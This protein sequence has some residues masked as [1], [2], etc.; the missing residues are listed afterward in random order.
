MFETLW[1]TPGADISC[2]E[3]SDEKYFHITLGGLLLDPKHPIYNWTSFGAQTEIFGTERPLVLGIFTF[4]WSKIRNEKHAEMDN[5]LAKNLGVYIPPPP[6]PNPGSLK[7]LLEWKS[8]E[9]VDP[10]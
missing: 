10:V 3:G 6:P 5:W 4:V 9:N 2:W 1:P 7:Q 8:S